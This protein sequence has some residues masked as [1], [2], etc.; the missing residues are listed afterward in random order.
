LDR[1]VG[2]KISPF[3]WKKV[4][5]GLSAG[6]VQ[7]VAVRLIVERENE[8]RGFKPEEYW[9]I[10]AQFINGFDAELSKIDGK[11]LDK[12]AV[13]NE[14]EADKI[15]V[16]LKKQNFVIAAINKKINIKNPLPPFITSTLQQESVKR[17]GYS[18]KKT[19]F[20]A[21]RLYER[22]L[23]TYMRTDSVNL[24]QEALT[25][26]KAWLEKEYG[27]EYAVSAPRVFT[28]KSKLAQEAH[29]AIRPTN[30]GKSADELEDESD[31]KLYRLIWQRFVASQMPPAKVAVTSV[32]VAAGSYTLKTSGQQI[33]FDGYLKV[34]PQ[35]F[36]EKTLPELREG[37]ELELKDIL[38]EQHFTEPPARYSEASL[39][40]T[41]EEYGI[42]RP[43]T[44]APIISVIQLRN[45][46]KKEKG[47]FFPTEIGEIVNKV[48]TE[49]FPEIVD[50]DFTA[51]IETTLDEVAEGKEKWQDVMG[52]FYGP[53]SKNLEAK[54]EEVSKDEVMP[55]EQT[56]EK[57]EKCG[58]P[59]I[60]KYGR[61]GKFMACSGF[62]DCKTTKQLPKEA[63]KKIGMKCPR[64]NEGEI[65]E[66][67]VT[68]GRARGKIFWGCE[69]YPKCDYASWTNPLNPPEEK[70]KEKKL[71]PEQTEDDKPVEE[72]EKLTEE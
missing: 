5:R 67:R 20:I 69:N 54:Y 60:I 31:K 2:Y 41:L 7:S 53:F 37:Q 25:S 3:L 11:T 28:G 8:I 35:K 13:Q 38:P 21:Q 24:S 34:W 9:T 55:V 47:R 40:K 59:M 66:R 61:F 64:C 6:R 16:E 39:I 27:T 15:V 52:A 12:F 43:S 30:I 71:K 14:N 56:D 44:Y 32:E 45:Y 18:S 49:H 42:G 17:L 26:S 4:A 68:R 19:M 23:I 62:P 48:L 50:V 58:K 22:G 10:M 51:K 1:L 36:A 72:L 70:S 29:E 65:V 33:V 46:V 63:P 57:C